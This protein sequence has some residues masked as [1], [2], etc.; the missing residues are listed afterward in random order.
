MTTPGKRPGT[1]RNRKITSCRECHRLKLKCD[2][3]WPCSNCK[4]RGISDLCPDGIVISVSDK[5][6]KLLLSR[7]SKLQGAV[8]SYDSNHDSLFIAEHD[9]KVIHS[10][11]EKYIDPTEQPPLS[12]SFSAKT[13]SPSARNQ[14]AESKMDD[15]TQTSSPSGDSTLADVSQM[16]GR[17][18]IGSHGHLNYYGAS[19]SRSCIPQADPNSEEEDYFA[20]Q[21]SLLYPS[22]SSSSLLHWSHRVPNVLN[23]TNLCDMLPVPQF[24]VCLLNLYFD[25]VGWS[26]HVIH[27]PSFEKARL[28]LYAHDSS[29]SPPQPHFLALTYMV[30]CLGT[31]FASPAL[32]RNRKS[33][34]H[35]F[36]LRAQLCFDISYSSFVPSVDAVVFLILMCQYSYF[37]DCL[38]RTNFAW[39]CVGT[40]TRIAVAMGMHRDGE[41]FELSAFQLHMRRMIWAELLFLDRMLSMS[42][43]R[44]YAI[45]NDQTNVLPPSNIADA[46]IAPDSL[47]IP[48][49]SPL[50][51]EASFTIVKAKISK[52]LAN[53]LNRAF[54]F[55]PPSYSEV[56]TLTK[57]LLE[58]ESELP[59]Y[60]CVTDDTKNASPVIIME[61]YS[62]KFI[63]LQ[64]V[65]YLHRPW[66]VRAVTR[67]EE[68]NQY[69]T[70]LSLC[71]SVSHDLIHVLYSLMCLVPVEPL[72]W[73]VFRFHSLNAGI[74]Q[75]AYALSFPKTSYAM[76]AYNDLRYMC[77]IFEHLRDGFSFSNKDFAFLISLKDKVFERF[78][79][80][81]QGIDDEFLV[82]E[83]PFLQFNVPS[84]RSNSR[85][86]DDATENAEQLRQLNGLG[87]SMDQSTVAQSEHLPYYEQENPL[88][89]DSLS[90]HVPK[91]DFELYNHPETGLWDASNGT[92]S[93]NEKPFSPNLSMNL[94]QF[95]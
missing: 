39:N 84:S 36:Y 67:T 69:A 60:F 45:S 85:S 54:K 3:V 47:F 17:L 70:S 74:I 11:I 9:Q 62:I 16:L 12:L 55:T 21:R 1:R 23:P 78:Q 52:Y 14:S 37:C 44:P 30:F 32:V 26:C 89:F 38:E 56:Q 71:T 92:T 22:S 58:V 13:Q 68:R 28:N 65:L 63:I 66:F 57:E 43:G 53:A 35:E 61:Q 29:R 24:A 79:L 49:P 4:K 46:S 75:G 5:L 72:R 73:W 18:K 91:N 93:E 76:T 15:T 41:V 87:I 10:L 59:D 80:T 81:S 33:L 83:I 42:L 2:R 82:E 86:P 27:R 90:W 31:L 7:M 20:L 77:K 25:N 19:S 34:A 8:E 88:L 48:E 50:R 94:E 64:S 6:I 40:A 95:L 51:T